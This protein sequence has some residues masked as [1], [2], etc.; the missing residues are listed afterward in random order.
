MVHGPMEARKTGM[1]WT[2][3]DS[4]AEGCWGHLVDASLTTRESGHC[5]GLLSGGMGHHSSRKHSG[6]DMS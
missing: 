5:T 6:V 1:A 2:R 3:A 4:R